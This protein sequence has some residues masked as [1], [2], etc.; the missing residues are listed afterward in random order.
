MKRFLSANNNR[1]IRKCLLVLAVL[2]AATVEV[3]VLLTFLSVY[4]V[5]TIEWYWGSLVA[6][7]AVFFVSVHVLQAF[8]EVKIKP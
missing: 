3:A 2:S 8:A 6:L 4:N 5:I 7:L 1:M